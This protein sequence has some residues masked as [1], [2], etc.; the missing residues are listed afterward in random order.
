MV[1]KNGRFHC[2]D[3]SPRLII[4]FAKKKKHY[5]SFHCCLHYMFYIKPFF[6]FV[7]SYIYI[8]R[9]KVNSISIF[10]INWPI[11]ADYGAVIV[12]KCLQILSVFNQMSFHLEMLEN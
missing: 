8:N 7:T 9:E 4:D 6:K 5:H 10:I 1:I 3:N 12:L 11:I 2:S